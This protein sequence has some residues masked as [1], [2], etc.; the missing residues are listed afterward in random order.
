MNRKITW[1]FIAIIL[2]GLIAIKDYYWGY[3]AL[4]KSDLKVICTKTDWSLLKPWTWVKQPITQIL[5]LDQAVPINEDKN[6]FIATVFYKRQ[7]GDLIQT[8]D[9]IDIKN[10]RFIGIERKDVSKLLPDT[11]DKLNYIKADGCM[12]DLVTYLKNQALEY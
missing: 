10:N 2:V 12:S 4:T 5:W 7:G 8:I 11:L 9:V 1:T 3:Y 6:Y